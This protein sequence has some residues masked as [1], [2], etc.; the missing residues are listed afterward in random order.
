MSDPTFGNYL[1]SNRELFSGDSQGSANPPTRGGRTPFGNLDNRMGRNGRDG[2]ELLGLNPQDNVNRTNPLSIQLPGILLSPNHT[3]LR[4]EIQPTQEFSNPQEDLP[5]EARIIRLRSSISALESILISEIR[6]YNGRVD[7]A[8]DAELATRRNEILDIRDRQRAT[9][10]QAMSLQRH[11]DRTTL[12]NLLQTQ[13]TRRLNLG[14]GTRGFGLVQTLPT[15]DRLLRHRH[16]P[17]S[18]NIVDN[19]P[20]PGRDYDDGYHPF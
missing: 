13:E 12:L 16:N 17:L 19:P 10:A 14:D 3:P 1:F 4:N 2:S 5:I 9:E 15:P 11:L 20:I 7:V 6:L 8:D 18:N